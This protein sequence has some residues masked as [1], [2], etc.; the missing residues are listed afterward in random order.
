MGFKLENYET[1]ED[2]LE[3]FW[4]DFPAARIET[5][6]LAH[7]GGRF[8]V[9]SRLYR[10]AVDT[11]PFATGLAEETITER[12]VNS[13]SALENCETSSVGRALANAGY[14][15]RGKRPSRE[16]MAKVVRGDQ[17]HKVEHP[18]KPVEAVKEVPNEPETYVWPDE[19]ESK[20]FEDAV[21]IVAALGAEVIGFKCKHGDM[22]LKD[23]NKN[24]KPYHGYV[25]GS[26][27]KDDQCKGKWA[28]MVNGK[29][30][31]EDKAAW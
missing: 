5:E 24:G 8:I 6:L 20:A 22:L 19:T 26:R 11:L 25:C 7:E 28:T 16:E 14:A 2:R 4:N 15:A 17:G 30:T 23:G 31:F 13:T 18:F 3:K 29:W 27:S 21:D 12:G 9:Y 1:V 10:D